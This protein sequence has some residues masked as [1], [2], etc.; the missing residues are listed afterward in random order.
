MQKKWTARERLA[1]Y[2][3][4]MMGLDRK[5]IAKRLGRTYGSVDGFLRRPSIEASRRARKKAEG[6]KE[7][8]FFDQVRSIFVPPQLWIERERRLNE[9]RTL[10]QEL[11]GDP[12]FSQSALSKRSGVGKDREP[13]RVNAP[14]SGFQSAQPQSER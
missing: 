3:L 10:T 11:F 6:N 2:D 5:E 1:V 12:P 9:P 8:R 4:Q 14:F 13:L 7:R